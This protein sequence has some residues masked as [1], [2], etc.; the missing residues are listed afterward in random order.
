MGFPMFLLCSD[1]GSAHAYAPSGWDFMNLAEAVRS[2]LVQV[3]P[4]SDRIQRMSSEADLNNFMM[5]HPAGSAKPR[6]LIF[7]DDVRRPNLAA[8]NAAV[9]LSGSHH[10]AQLGA[11][12]WVIERFKLKQVPALIVIDPA[13]RQGATNV[14]V[15]M[16]D[17]TEGL[18]EQ[19]TSV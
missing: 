5:L 10:F 12:R 1:T 7:M 15:L 18:I 8:Y 19:I 11:P 6:V 14:P 17:H 16:K 9:R 3:M 4:Y 2:S 13:T